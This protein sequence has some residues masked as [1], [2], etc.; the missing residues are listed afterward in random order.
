METVSIFDYSLD[1][2]RE[3]AY[4][5]I[6]LTRREKVLQRKDTL[7]KFSI[8]NRDQDSIQPQ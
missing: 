5:S 2:L 1:V 3:C 7:L 8:K 6:E 4:S